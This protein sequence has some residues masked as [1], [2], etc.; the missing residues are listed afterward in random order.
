MPICPNCGGENTTSNELCAAC[1]A[2]SS[3]NRRFHN[4]LLIIL[5][6]A[7]AIAIA[8]L[9]HIFFRSRLLR[10]P[11]D[12]LP[13]STIIAVGTDL[14]PAS[15]AMRHLRQTWSQSDINHLARRGTHIAQQFVHWTGLQLDLEEE[16]SAWF[17]RELILAALAPSDPPPAGPPAF[18]LIARVTNT[19]RARISLDHAAEPL[20]RA[21]GWVR[22]VIR[23]NGHNIILWTRSSQRPAL[24]YAADE[25][26]LLIAADD[27]IV[28]ECLSAAAHPAERLT[29]TPEFAAAFRGLP[30]DSL[31]W[32]YAGILPL[33]RHLQQAL[34]HLRRGWL[35]LLQYYR[36]GMP[37]PPPSRGPA[38]R[39]AQAS[40]GVL[41][42]ALTPESDGIR[43]LG[44][45]RGGPPREPQSSQQWSALAE[46]LP[47]E[48]I[49]Y[50][51]VHEPLRWL[52]A[53]LPSL[54]PLP[55]RRGAPPLIPPART[56]LPLAIES[57]GLRETPTDAL[58]ALLPRNGQP[59]P[60]L[61]LAL[62]N[63][64]PAPVPRRIP[65]PISPVAKEQIGDMLIVASD[66]EAL[67]QCRRAAGDA[68]TR[69][70]PEL[71]PTAQLQAWARPGKISPALADFE[72]LQLQVRE[73]LEGGEGEVLL[74]ASPRA[75]L[76]GG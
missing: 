11:G 57:L 38:P 64:Q 6:L 25:G 33:Q 7:A 23:R 48:A 2:R 4:Y 32:G 26:C 16:A 67:A 76:G 8:L 12:F 9:T 66:Q 21:G 45:Y 53:L 20:A 74:R 49:A 35:P 22:S 29:S 31:I 72:E 34:P 56:L 43:L 28:E 65:P 24:A 60:A 30:P 47:Q 19:R 52:R 62:P 42:L 46:V 3:H 41:A 58:L 27:R 44:A 40:S 36:R 61:L 14:R 59:H 63:P 70:T 73:G 55:A 68:S 69:L 15:P 13:A 54:E 5:A 75:L 50:A 37:P 18:V 51:F 1:T 71:E 10:P 17:D 39:P